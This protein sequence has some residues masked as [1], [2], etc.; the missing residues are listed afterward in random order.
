MTAARPYNSHPFAALLMMRGTFSVR[1]LT[2]SDLE[3]F[4][5]DLDRS[6][7]EDAW[8][9]ELLSAVEAEDVW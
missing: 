9:A 1:S 5:S 4:A 7:A 6:D 3:E 2:W 8:Q